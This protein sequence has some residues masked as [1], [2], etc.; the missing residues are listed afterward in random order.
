MLGT[1]EWLA[2]ASE[3]QVHRLLRPGI[4][5]VILEWRGRSATFLPQVWAQLPEPVDFLRALKR[6]AE[7]PADF[8]AADLRLARYAVRKF[9]E[10]P[11]PADEALA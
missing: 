6:K 4:D 1:A 3:A 11:A 10:Q 7:L 2:A 8:W 5:G 9:V